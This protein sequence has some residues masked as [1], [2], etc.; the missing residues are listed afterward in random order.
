MLLCLVVRIIVA[1]LQCTILKFTKLSRPKSSVK[2]VHK[3]NS[4]HISLLPI[5]SRLAS[6]YKR[7]TFNN[8]D[9]LSALVMQILYESNNS[10]SLWSACWGWL[11]PQ[12]L[13][14]RQLCS[15]LLW[16]RSLFWILLLYCSLLLID[17]IY[18]INQRLTNQI[19][20]LGGLVVGYLLRDIYLNMQV[21]PGS[22]PGQGFLQLISLFLAL[23]LV[24]CVKSLVAEWWSC[25]L[26]RW[27]SDS[28]FWVARE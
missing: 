26:A 27:D 13:Q 10:L 3:L 12:P 22:I 7:S 20:S 5:T 16:Y 18:M 23:F 24:L 6:F 25:V 19:K 15:V 28:N 17:H 9:K 2:E 8:I 14:T 11:H 4:P 21:I 1:R